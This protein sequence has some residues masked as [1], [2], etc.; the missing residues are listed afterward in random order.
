MFSLP[1]GRQTRSAEAEQGVRVRD[2]CL[3][4]KIAP[5]RESPPRAEGLVALVVVLISRHNVGG[6]GRCHVESNLHAAS[7]AVLTGLAE[8]L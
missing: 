5:Q 6:F 7:V 8:S 4:G 3:K 2:A 1:S